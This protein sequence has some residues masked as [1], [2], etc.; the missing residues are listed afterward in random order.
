MHVSVCRYTPDHVAKACLAVRKNE[1]IRRSLHWISFLMLKW[2]QWWTEGKYAPR[3][4]FKDTSKSHW[5]RA[6]MWSPYRGCLFPLS[7]VAAL[8]MIKLCKAVVL[9]LEYEFESCQCLLLLPLARGSIFS[10]VTLWLPH[11]LW[12]TLNPKIHLLSDCQVCEQHFVCAMRTYAV[13]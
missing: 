11:R 6:W 5:T 8:L 2:Q 7:V 10:D 9:R 13:K 4:K 12:R 3:R 1:G